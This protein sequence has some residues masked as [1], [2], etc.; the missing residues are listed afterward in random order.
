MK[1]LKK[2]QQCHYC[3]YC[4]KEGVKTKALWRTT[5]HFDPTEMACDSHKEMLR[6]QELK[7]QKMNAHKTE[8]DLQLFGDKF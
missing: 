4:K 5:G 7:D 3:F 6:Q 8:A 1:K 2:K